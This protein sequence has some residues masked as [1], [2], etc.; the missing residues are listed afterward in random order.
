MDNQWNNSDPNNGSSTNT[1][2]PTV[3]DFTGFSPVVEDEV[4][5]RPKH[6]GLGIASFS[7]FGGMAVLFIIL[8]VVFVSKITSLDLSDPDAIASQVEEMPE[9]GVISFLMF[10]TLIGNL[11][12]LVLGIIGLVQKGRKKIFAILGTIFNG[13]VVGFLALLLIIAIGAALAG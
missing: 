4:V 8:L 7:L 6:S 13:L 12:G 2:K 1:G 3:P 10:G 9:L 11:I 5:L